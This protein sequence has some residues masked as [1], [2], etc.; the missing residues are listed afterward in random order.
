MKTIAIANQKGGVGKTTTALCLADMMQRKGFRVLL[1]DMDPQ[2]NSTSTYQ[3][4]TEDTCTMFDFFKRECTLPE[5]V[6][7]TESGDIV[8]NDPDLAGIEAEFT[9]K[10]KSFMLLRLALDEVREDYD[11]AVIDT[12]P[13]LGL[14][15]TS[16]LI[17]AD[18]VIIPIK[19]EIYAIDGLNQ[20]ISNI[21]EAS[22]LNPGLKIYGV[23]HTVYD[24]R[25]ALD[26]EMQE[27]LPEKGK[28]MGFPV[29]RTPIRISQAVKE[30]QNMR[31]RLSEYAPKCNAAQDYQS[32]LEEIIKEAKE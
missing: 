25:T 24:K 30:A 4:A 26:R 2:C 3:A 20:I 17:A 13:A 18:G 27:G 19:A 23:L 15:M 14:Y 21:E 10:A 1:I 28:E 16:A 22:A 29:F 8:P 32:I 6:Q 9:G 5:A 12:P 7:H 11:F 31:T